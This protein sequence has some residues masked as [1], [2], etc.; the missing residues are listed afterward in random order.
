LSR[1][2]R[3][4]KFAGNVEKRGIVSKEREAAKEAS[5]ARERTFSRFSASLTWV[6]GNGDRLHRSC[7]L[8]VRGGGRS[9]A[10]DF[11]RLVMRNDEKDKKVWWNR[12]I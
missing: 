10:G 6:A 5:E 2:A 9:R 7:V 8:A 12:K 3:S 11:P 4:E 1:K